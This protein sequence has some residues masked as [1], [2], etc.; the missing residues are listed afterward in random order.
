MPLVERS[1]SSIVGSPGISGYSGTRMSIR[2]PA[3]TLLEEGTERHDY[4]D[5]DV[6]DGLSNQEAVPLLSQAVPSTLRD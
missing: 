4:D 6:E 5:D 3:G 1:D 2:P